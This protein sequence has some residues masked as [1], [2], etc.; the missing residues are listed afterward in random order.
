MGNVD[1]M[2]RIVIALVIGVLY[3]QNVISETLGIVL[4]TL[5]V[6]FLLTSTVNFCPIYKVLGIS[7][8]NK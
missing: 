4:A 3:W 2:I 7:S 8:S 5:A 1:R 6:I